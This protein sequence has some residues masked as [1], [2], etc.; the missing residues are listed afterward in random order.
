MIG[1]IAAGNAVILKPSELSLNAAEA[2]AKL[3]PKYLDH[4]CYHVVMGG[5]AETQ[6][7]LK[8]RFDYIFYTGSPQVGK[9][10]H[11]AAAQHL[12]PC[13]LE[14]GGKR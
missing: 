9:I 1:A 14:L 11:Q 8:Q 6:A 4:E 5:A 7:L 12:T 13:T 2:F 3:I 10:I